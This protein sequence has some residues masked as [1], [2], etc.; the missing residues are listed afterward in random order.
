[1]GLLQNGYR[2]NLIG[3]IV[4]TTNLDGWR[5]EVGV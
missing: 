3:R 1:M 5:P 4:G 2:H